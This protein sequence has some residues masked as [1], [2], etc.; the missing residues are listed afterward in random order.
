MFNLII[1]PVAE[2]QISAL[3]DHALHPL[4]DLFALLETAPWKLTA[5]VRFPSPAPQQKA[6]VD[7]NFQDLGFDLVRAY[8]S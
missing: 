5:Q 4:P 7:R 2:E 3:P 1:D 6:Q 8:W